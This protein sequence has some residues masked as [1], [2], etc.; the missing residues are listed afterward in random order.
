MSEVQPHQQIWQ[1]FVE[2]CVCVCTESDTQL[3]KTWKSYFC[4]W[5][6]IV[7][8]KELWLNSLTISIIYCHVNKVDRNCLGLFVN[9]KQILCVQAPNGGLL[10]VVS[11][12]S[13]TNHC[14]HLYTNYIWSLCFKCSSSYISLSYLF[15]QFRSCLFYSRVFA[16]S[17]SFVLGL[18]SFWLWEVLN[19]QKILVWNSQN[20]I[21]L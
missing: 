16:I 20:V 18:H 15:Y 2:D 1:K 7:N 19:T 13:T 12:Y 11:R 4:F 9:V 10:F 5:T 21:L 6:N 17:M 14:L 8:D 3:K